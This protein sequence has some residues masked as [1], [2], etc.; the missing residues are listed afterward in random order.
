MPIKRRSLLQG[1][2]TGTGLA[3]AGQTMGCQPSTA[4]E[5]TWVMPDETEP[6]RRT[7]MSFG[8]QRAIWGS[9]LLPA[10]QDTLAMIANAIADYEPVAMLVRP[11]DRA[12]AARKCSRAIELIT[13]PLDDLWMRDIGPVFVKNAQGQLGGI[14]FNFNGWGGKQTHRND[15]RVARRVLEHLG[16]DAIATDLVLEGGGIEVDGQG[17]AIITESCVLNANRNPGLD[18]A[19][20]EA[21]LKPLLGLRKIIWLPGIRGRDMTDG[22]TDFYARFAQPGIVIAAYDPDPDSFDHAVTR[23]HLDIL[24]H[25]TDADDRPLEVVVLES[26]QQIRPTFDNDDFAAGY[27]NFYCV[28]GAILVPEFGD[29]IADQRAQGILQDLFPQRDIL[30]LD[31]DAIAAGGGGI[32]CTTQQEP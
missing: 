14:D 32:H 18:K 21:Q 15:A 10:V 20:C 9:D 7:W 30:Q 22:H 24:R 11:A 23:R 27:V 28:N 8:A 3:I 26:P 13:A 5:P 16:M 6:H 19:T 31:I 2:I 12:I 1:L 29:A 4:I 25:A 17:T